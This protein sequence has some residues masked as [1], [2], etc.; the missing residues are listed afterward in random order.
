MIHLPNLTML[1]IDCAYHGAA[2][3]AIKKSLQ[4]IKP[5]KTVFITDIDLKIDGVETV[6][7]P[8]I[9]SK[10]E[11]SSFCIKELYKYF[12]T[13]YALLIQHDGYVINGDVWDDKWLQYDFIAAPWL[14]PD[15]ERNV[16]NGAASLRS[17][18]LQTILGTDPFIE[19]IEPE[20]EIIGRL[21]RRYLEQKHGIIFAPEEEADKFAFELRTPKQKTFAFHGRFHEPYRDMVIIRREGAMGDVIQTEAVLEYFHNKGYRVVLETLPQF[22][23]LFQRHYFPVLFPHQIDPRVLATA[24]RYNLDMTYE[25]DPKKLH[26]QAYFEFCGIKDYKLRN[27]KLSLGFEI[28]DQIRMFKK[29]AI[30]HIDKRAQPHRNISNVDWYRIVQHLNEKRYTVIQLGK[31]EH[32]TVK[33]AIE[34][35]TVNENLLAYVCAGASLMIGIDSGISHI[36]AGFGVPMVLFFGSVNPEYIHANLENIIPIH[37]HEEKVCETPYCWSNVIGCEGQGCTVD[38]EY[39]PCTDFTNGYTQ[40]TIDAINKLING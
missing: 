9:K 8:K 3:S 40:K 14:Y 1:C 24:K 5:A 26:L 34:M 19:I 13:D 21:Y 17:K 18:K 39:P 7:I 27:P 2:V 31:G 12:D 28:N 38:K 10:E 11:Y 16:G 25:S 6:L 36:C 35:N 29:Y 30:L 4:Q 15:P 37:R 20:D 33:G 32:L 23:A 22:E